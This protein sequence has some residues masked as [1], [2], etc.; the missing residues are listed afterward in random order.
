MN[1]NEFSNGYA[2]IIGVGADLPVTVKDAQAIYNVLR[3]SGRC[4]Y[5]EN[6][7]QL[8]T[9]A[10]ANRKNIITEL[11]RLSKVSKE[12]PESTIIIYFSGHG[13]HMPDY[14]MVPYGYNPNDI[15]NTAI[16]G[17][18]FTNKLRSIKSKKLLVLL[19]CCHAGGVA[20]VKGF[21]KA[22]APTDLFES[23]SKSSGRVIIASSQQNEVSYTGTPFSE[24][25]KS[26]L[27]G[28]CGLGA[29]EK[30]GY[31]RVLDIA[32]YVGR[33]VP[34]RTQDKQHPIIK[35]NNLEDNFI[36]AFYAGGS[37]EP[38]PTSEVFPVQ[39]NHHSKG[40]IEQK[41]LQ[42]LCEQYKSDPG[43]MFNSKV[44]CTDL[45]LS[46]DEI[47]QLVLPL[48]EKGFIKAEYVGKIAA[49]KITDLGRMLIEG[50]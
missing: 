46:L 6:Q 47:N 40:E 13:G 7:V 24:F 2:L 45:G 22:P 34:N 49:L 33:W 29:S 35:V 42:W 19:D 38:K 16:S 36:L 3:D 43:K 26:L 12:N 48:L 50:Q 23:L 18:V 15:D 17:N 9:E 31:A 21:N 14:Y 32:M 1:L 27:E 4:A 11:E 39:I 30:D 28:F 8:L 20:D 41:I 25:T 5:P 37:K 44:M 10:Q